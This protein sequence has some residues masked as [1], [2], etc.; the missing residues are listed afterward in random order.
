MKSRF[1]LAA[2]VLWL[3]FAPAASPAAE[4]RCPFDE[5]KLEFVGTPLEQARCLLRP[6]AEFS[7]L[8][9]P[10]TTLPRPLESLIGRRVTV[11][12]EKLERYLEEHDIQETEI[13]GAITN[14][15]R[16]KYFVIHDVSAP[17][18]HE[19]SF[20]TN[21]NEADWKWNDLNRWRSDQAAH[22]FVNRLGQSVAPH[23]LTTPWRAT[24][25][26]VRVLGEK[27]RGLFVHTEL[28]QPRRADPQGH[29]GNDGIAPLPG[30]TE[31]QLDRL[32]LI[33]LVASS[34][35]GTWM[36]PAYHAAIDAGIPDGHDDPQNFDLALWADRLRLLLNAVSAE[37]QPTD[38][39][40]INF[41]RR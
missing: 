11:N 21:I 17:N 28:I 36:V 30:F 13:G 35:H 10:L 15:L 31:A 5:T 18:Y 37:P 39:R 24:K 27:S 34:E 32:A 1:C 41:N 16:A 8:G 19:Q 26:E 14:V 22:F 40:K 4:T 12:K 29:P 33:Y 38:E 6:V 2:C 9:Q 7:R 23:T 3:V 20:P 25:L